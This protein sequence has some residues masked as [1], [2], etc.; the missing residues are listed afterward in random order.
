M[1][2]D[3]DV[4][5]G[6]NLSDDLSRINALLP[7]WQRFGDEMAEECQAAAHRLFLDLMSESAAENPIE[8]LL[9]VNLVVVQAAALNC[10]QR[11]PN[12]FGPKGQSYLRQ[13][14]RL[15]E[16]CRRLANALSREQTSRRRKAREAAA[17]EAASPREAEESERT[18][19]A[20]APPPRPRT[21]AVGRTGGP[22]ADRRSDDH[23]PAGKPRP[24][25]S[26][27]PG[28]APP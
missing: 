1:H 25:R 10:L 9:A 20:A 23:R 27:P 14:A 7:L 24:A 22:M 16:L 17:A 5:A 4:A 8:R 21:A 12:T 28:R 3:P 26:G 18:V 13:G 2:A 11:D 15:M 6:E 19:K